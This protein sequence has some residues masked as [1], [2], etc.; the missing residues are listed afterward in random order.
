MRR[1]SLPALARG[2]RTESVSASALR[3]D[4]LEQGGD[5][6]VAESLLGG[7]TQR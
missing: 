5:V 6:V 4:D 2:D 1:P 7:G 3:I